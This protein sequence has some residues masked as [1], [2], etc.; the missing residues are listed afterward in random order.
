MQRAYFVTGT[1]TGVGKTLVSSALLHGYARQ[2]LTVIGMKPV[3]SGAVWRNGEVCW[4]DVMQ[5]QA[6]S[7]VEM[8]LAMR[9]PYRFTAPIAPHIAARQ[10]GERIEI[11]PLLQAFRQLQHAA[12]VVIVEGSG[13][14][15]TPLNATETLA[16]LARQMDLPV[17]LVVALR[18]GCINHAL[19][20]EQALI[21][22]GLRLAG[23]VANQM[24]PQMLAMD[25]NLADLQQRMAAP[26][27]GVLPWQ[28]NPGAETALLHLHMERL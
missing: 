5:L 25:D 11:A 13:G 23:W 19:L 8:P 2:G 24:V 20:T 15:Y 21:S 9:N 7:N 3:V 22:Q 6:A 27:L 14:F 28:R 18:L 26:L 10:A 12:E 4:E 1:D 16:D 17:I